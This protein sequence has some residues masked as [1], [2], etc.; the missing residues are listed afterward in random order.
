MKVEDFLPHFSELNRA[1]LKRF[2]PNVQSPY[3]MGLHRFDFQISCVN[4][5]KGSAVRLRP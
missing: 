5:R 4:C 1:I 3:Y 2:R